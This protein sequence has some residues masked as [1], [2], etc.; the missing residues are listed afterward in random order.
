MA[1]I[2]VKEANDRGIRVFVGGCVERG[3]G[4][5]F[6]AKAHAHC[7]PSDKHRNWVCIRSA[8]RL[9]TP[10]GLPSLL[11]WEEIAHCLIPFSNG[12]NATFYRKLK[13]LS[14]VMPKHGKQVVARQRHF[15]KKY[16]RRRQRR[17]RLV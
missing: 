17:N 7:Y 13:E 12:H 1:E 15:S 2:K 8:K 5:S 6:R 9:L 11:L 16:A 4:S 3:D 10:A 14:G